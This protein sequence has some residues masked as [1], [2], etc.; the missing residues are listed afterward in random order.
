[1]PT[2]RVHLRRATT[3]RWDW[4]QI[5]TADDAAA[6]ISRAYITWMKSTFHAWVPRLLDCQSLTEEINDGS[7][8][9]ETL[10]LNLRPLA[11]DEEKAGIASEKWKQPF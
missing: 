3:H 1:M 6:A 8:P 2:Y 11:L 5:V 7:T 9:A 4:V 10:P